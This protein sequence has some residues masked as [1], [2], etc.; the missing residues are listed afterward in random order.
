MHLL[1]PPDIEGESRENEK[2][3]KHTHQDTSFLGNFDNSYMQLPSL[4]MGTWFK[5]V[6]TAP[7]S[8]ELFTGNYSR[9][10]LV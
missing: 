1:V 9:L 8:T 4:K 2:H 3:D 6:L 5:F 7:I 10:E